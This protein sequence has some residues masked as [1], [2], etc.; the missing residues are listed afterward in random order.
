MNYFFRVYFIKILLLLILG[1]Q[2]FSQILRLVVTFINNR[3]AKLAVN[4]LPSKTRVLM[5]LMLTSLVFSTFM[6]YAKV[7]KTNCEDPFGVQTSPMVWFEWLNSVPY[8]FFTVSVIDSEKKY[9]NRDD[10]IIQLCSFLGLLCGFATNIP[11]VVEKVSVGYVLLPCAMSLM[12]Y[13]MFRQLSVAYAE[14]LTRLDAFGKFE[15][16]A[17]SLEVN[18]KGGDFKTVHD[19]MRI[20]RSRLNC[21]SFIAFFFLAYPANYFL[22]AGGF[23]DSHTYGIIVTLL[24]FF[25][26]G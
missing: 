11:M 24:G 6:S 2:I 10:I 7:F 13:A 9:L 5:L 3:N 8:M 21:S 14:Y 1:A 4:T 26:K 12:G 18:K 17:A 15:S 23:M 22:A 20:S 19:Q 25:V 16:N